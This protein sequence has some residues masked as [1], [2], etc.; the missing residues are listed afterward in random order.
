MRLFILFL[1]LFCQ[2]LIL[3]ADR[4]NVLLILVDDLKPALG[5]YGDT[6]AVT[7]N[8]DDL[9]ARGTRFAKAYC[10]QAV[11]APSRYNLMLG[12]HSTT[13]GLYGL[14]SNLRA[15]LP[16]AITFPQHFSA[17][18]YRTESLGKIFH[19]G[20]GNQGDPTSFSVPHFKEKV[21]EYVDPTS[22]PGGELTR[23]EAMFENVPAP[24]GGMN[25]LPRGAAFESP[26]VGDE[27]YADGRVATETIRRL[28][29]AKTRREADDTPFFIA[30]G[31]ARPH[32][33]FSAPKRYW[34]LYQPEQ[35]ELA[36][37]PELPE[38]APSTAGKRGGE[39][40]NYFPVPDKSDPATIT[41]DTAR[42][43]IHGYYASTSY[44]DAQIGKVLESLSDLGLAEDTIVVLWG[45]HGF[46]L[47]DLGIWTKHT[48][49]EQAN[50]IPIILAGPGIPSGLVSDQLASSIDV[51][52]TVAALAG[53]P[54]PEGPQPIDGLSL[55]P[56]LD[57]PSETVRDHVFHAYPKQK[58]GR[59]IRTDRYRLVEWKRPGG[60][61]DSAELELY[62]YQTD[63]L[64]LRNL[65]AD[66]PDTV[67]KLRAILDQY[68]EAVPKA[69][70]RRPSQDPVA[71]AR[72]HSPLIANRP[73][74]ITAELNLHR[75]DGDSVNGVVLA[76][77]GRE[78]GY[79]IHFRNSIPRFDV[80]INGVVTSLVLAEAVG[81]PT[82]IKATLT[83][84]QMT[85]HVNDFDPVSAA[86][87]GLIPKEPQDPLTIGRDLLTAAGDYEAPNTFS[88][89]LQGA[90]VDTGATPPVIPSP[91]PP[92]R[93]AQRFKSHDRAFR[94]T[95][96]WIRDPYLVR[97]PQGGHY[98]TGTTPLPGDQREVNDPYN[99]G[100]GETSLVGWKARVWKSSDFT[101]W[102]PVTEEGTPFTLLDGIWPKEEPAAF[103]GEDRS[104]WRLWAPELHWID[105]LERW[106][107]VHTSP[108]PVAG[109][110]LSLSAGPEPVGPWTNPFGADL[111]K[112]HDPSLFKDDD[113]TWYL[114]WGATQIAPLKPDFS[115]FAAKPLAIKPQPT[116]GTSGKMGHEGCL[117][118]KIEGKYVLFGTGWSTGNMRRGSY[119][120]YY[121]TADQIEGPYSERKFVGRFLGHGTP[122]QDDQGR[123]WCT[124]FYNANVPPLPRDGIQTTDLSAT[125]HTINQR[126]VT[127]VPLDVIKTA[128]KE[129][130][131]RAKDPAYQTVGP[132]EAQSF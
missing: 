98:L 8:I 35:F 127:I 104:Q 33:P 56:S 64:E 63:P 62:D 21:I 14:G 39:I 101:E 116:P 60:A 10:N 5:C 25:Q 31:F 95:S 61:R 45:D 34:D 118:M 99:T 1:T 20:H 15:T 88:H 90:R 6:D 46:H 38:D 66:D 102:I 43:L 115:G 76:Q 11:C 103:S 131:I 51:F 77:G 109:A 85:L 52:P 89:M 129:L 108:S 27:A 81:G 32:L 111:G 37:N 41:D 13:T 75:R 2:T 16:D 22:K 114:I 36:T 92:K 72:E 100:L 83:E 97:S 132:D 69:S 119:N 124:A 30:A 122:F 121:A 80:R 23:E 57:D 50:H 68:P 130:I 58:L 19:I 42:R 107:M 123:W 82:R 28:E 105:H 112:K 65:A 117:I 17:H 106:A 18:G 47:G 9:A 113:G 91:D 59:A 29:A 12:S 128:N 120:L 78:Q 110:N 94:M 71:I 55:K 67:A 86:S 4:P 73:L 48:N 3:G 125:A 53:L 24:P 96:G 84:Q 79:A 49:Y 40:R 74:T 93:I 26:D 54:E 7:P 87:P 70:P 44:V 126:G